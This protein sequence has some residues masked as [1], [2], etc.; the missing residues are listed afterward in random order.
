M[1]LALQQRDDTA[2]SGGIVIRW[3]VQLC[4]TVQ[5]TDAQDLAQPSHSNGSQLWPCS[6]HARPGLNWTELATD[7]QGSK[8]QESIG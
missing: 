7:Q 8:R 3:P 6:V 1:L 2:N 5:H 4:V